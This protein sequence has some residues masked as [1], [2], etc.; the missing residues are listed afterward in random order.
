[1]CVIVGTWYEGVIV[2]AIQADMFTVHYKGWEPQFDEHHHRMS[3]TLQPRYTRV[4]IGQ[5]NKHNSIWMLQE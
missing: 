4:K 5:T 3:D 2:L 1:M